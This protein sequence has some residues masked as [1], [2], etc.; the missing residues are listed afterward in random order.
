[1]LSL[2]CNTAQLFSSKVL[3]EILDVLMK[4]AI[5]SKQLTI[6]IHFANR[7]ASGLNL[8]LALSN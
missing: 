3:S 4:S 7:G 5:L 6:F 8:V 1:M 2:Q